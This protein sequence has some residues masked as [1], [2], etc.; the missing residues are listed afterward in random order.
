MCAR[1]IPSA[2]RI[3]ADECHVAAFCDELPFRSALFAA[4]R[5]GGERPA[6]VTSERV[7]SYRALDRE[8]DRVRDALLR[9][10]PG[11]GTVV[12]LAPPHGWAWA[13]ALSAVLRCGAVLAPATARS[14][15]SP[16]AHRRH[17][18]FTADGTAAL[19]PE[20]FAAPRTRL[21]LARTGTTARLLRELLGA[22]LRVRV[23]RR[24][25]GA[26]GLPG[27]DARAPLRLRASERVAVRRS[28][29]LPPGGTTV[30]AGR[31]LGAVGRR[32][33]TGRAPGEHPEN[34]REPLGAAL[35]PTRR[36]RVPPGCGLARRDADDGGRPAAVRHCLILDRDRRTPAL[37]IQERFHPALS[38][39]TTL[40]RPAGSRSG[41]SVADRP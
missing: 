11:P 33:W 9:S 39:P 31:V 15:P 28:L 10:G 4:V 27:P 6:L 20:A 24:S 29:L 3:K 5:T 41:R 40:P 17:S 25:P 21:L 38:G 1:R 34:T 13:V 23:L 8:S 32:P 14:P 2:L 16:P 19:T 26:S 37:C 35:A 12:S 7:L 30:S 22:P 18:P 36:P